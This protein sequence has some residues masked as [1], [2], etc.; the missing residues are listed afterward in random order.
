MKRRGPDNQSFFK[1]KT[2]RKEIALLHS[3]LNI[4]DLDKRSNQPF[5]EKNLVLIFNGEIYNYI[6]LKNF[7]KKKN[8]KFK[9][10]SDTEVL[11]KSYQEWGEKCVEYF[12]GMWAFAIW[13]QKKEKLFLSRDNFGEKPLYYTFDKDGFFFGSEIKFIKSLSSKHFN[14]NKQKLYNYLFDGYKTMYKD[15]NTFFKNIY[16]LENATNLSIDLNFKIRKKKYWKPKFNIN[17]EISYNDAVREVQSLL[18]KSMNY[19]MRSDVPIAFCLSGGIDSGYLFSLGSKISE[20]KINS[21]SIIDHDV[22]YNELSNIEAL[23]K[24]K[25]TKNTKINIASKKKNFFERI[26]EITKYQDSPIS[27]ISYYIHSY[28]SENISNNKFRIA[29]SGTGADELFTGYYDHFLLQLATINKTNFYKQKLLE[30][31]KYI[32]PIIRNEYLKN[33]EIYIKNPNNRS[34]VFEKG[35]NLNRFIKNNKEMFY[36]EKKY[37]NELLRNR[38]LNELFHEVVPCILKDDDHN[39]MNYSVENRSPYLDKDLLNFSL[40]LPPEMLISDGYQKKVLRDA[41]KGILPDS[42]RLERR[43]KGF[44]ASISSII[45]LN[46]SKNIDYIFDKKL[47]INEFL[48]LTKLKETINFKDIPNHYSQFLFRILTAESFLKF[49]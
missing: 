41:S 28:L 24:N 18:D 16:L 6:E 48:N 25:N 35:F 3:R 34:L 21:F 33:H 43:K 45:D 32:K 7:L 17:Y 49:N 12:I 11:I 47:N 13:D 44:N 19:R 31:K 14:I 29:I 26:N 15:K 38:M 30:W 46:D 27:T 20:K 22:R 23:L 2:V 39:S 42:I 36:K 1:K 5:I 4:I 9:T 37:C 40:S 8:Y 10:N